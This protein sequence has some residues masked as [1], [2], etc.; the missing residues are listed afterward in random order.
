MK[1]PYSMS[2]TVKVKTQQFMRRKLNLFKKADQLVKLCNADLT[3]IICKNSRYFTYQLTD[4]ES[5][6]LLMKEIVYLSCSSEE[7]T[8]LFRKWSIHYSSICFLRIFKVKKM[9]KS[10]QLSALCRQVLCEMLHNIIRIMREVLSFAVR[11]AL[12]LKAASRKQ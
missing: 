9:C 8:N 11:L 10:L 5:W 7:L 2:Y 6:S 4:K 1:K 12:L 3:L